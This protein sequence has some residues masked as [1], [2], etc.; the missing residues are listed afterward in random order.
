MRIQLQNPPYIFARNS[1]GRLVQIAG[2]AGDVGRIANV[3][4]PDEHT[5]QRLKPAIRYFGK[6]SL[7]RFEYGAGSAGEKSSHHQDVVKPVQ[8]NR[9]DDLLLFEKRQ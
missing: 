6:L 4:V 7:G 8:F 2:R 5:I 1:S 9:T 3:V